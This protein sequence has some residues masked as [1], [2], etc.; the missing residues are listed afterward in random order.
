M[1]TLLNAIKQL[2]IE[3]S[4]DTLQIRPIQL[5]RSLPVENIYCD[6]RSLKINTV[7]V[8]ILV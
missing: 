1:L 2:N 4:R 5:I 8:V 6:G 3:V 7:S